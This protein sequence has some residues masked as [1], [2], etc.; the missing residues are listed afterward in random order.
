MDPLTGASAFATIV[1]LLCNWK[2]ERGSQDQKRFESF[3]TWLEV[4]HFEGLKDRIFESDELQRSLHQLLGNDLNSLS[5]K[6]DALTSSLSAVAERIDGFDAVGES[7]STPGELLSEQGFALLKAFAS[8]E[9]AAEMILFHRNFLGG[10]SMTDIHF[11]PAGGS[12]EVTEA[13]FIKDDLTALQFL[14]LIRHSDSNNDGDP[15]YSLTRAGL[16]VATQ[17]SSPK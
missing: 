10:D 5:K 13:R 14:G 17:S 12:F 4:H 11:L 6:L 15:I 3:I 16:K 7:L 2:Q 1:G 9:G 8:N